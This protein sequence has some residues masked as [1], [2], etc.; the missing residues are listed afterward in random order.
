MT[1]GQM[2]LIRQIV[3]EQLNDYLAEELEADILEGITEG[4]NDNMALFEMLATA[5]TDEE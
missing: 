3:S 5:E 1:D 2:D 4:L